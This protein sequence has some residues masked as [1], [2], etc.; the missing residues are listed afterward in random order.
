MV[1]S[2]KKDYSLRHE[3]D[4][5]NGDDLPKRSPEIVTIFEGTI[6]QRWYLRN[7]GTISQRSSLFLRVQS[8]IE[9]VMYFIMDDRHGDC[10]CKIEVPSLWRWFKSG[11]QSPWRSYLNFSSAISGRLYLYFASVISWRWY[12]NFSSTISGDV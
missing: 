7:S 9:I 12:L 5:K 2:I 1:Y 6:S 8:L 11:G 4:P 3:T 10:T